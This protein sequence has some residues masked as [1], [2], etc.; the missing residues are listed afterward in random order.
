[1]ANAIRCIRVCASIEMNPFRPIADWLRRARRRNEVSD[2]PRVERDGSVRGRQDQTLDRLRETEQRFSFLVRATGDAVYDWDFETGQIEWNVGRDTMFG[3]PLDTVKPDLAWW[4]HKLHPDERDRIM[5]SLEEAIE[6]PEPSWLEEYRFRRADGGWGWVLDRGYFV[7]DESGRAVRMIGALQDLTN[8]HAEEQVLRES[9]SHFRALIENVSDGII[10]VDHDGIIRYASPSM[11]RLLGYPPSDLIGMQ[12]DDLVHPEDRARAAVGLT[13]RIHVPENTFS[14]TYRLRHRNGSWRS[15]EAV[16]SNLPP[17][18][19][20]GAVVNLR[21]LTERLALEKQLEQS[22][23]LSKLGRL[24]ATVAHEFNNVLMGIQPFAELI[25]RSRDD[26][27]VENATNRI[28]ASVQRGKNIAQEI[29]RYTRPTEPTLQAIDLREW[30]KTLRAELSGLMGSR[31]DLDIRDV[32]EPLYVLGDPL[33]MTQ[34]LVNLAINARDAMPEGGTLTIIAEEAMSWRDFSFGVVPTP[35]RFIHFI[36]RDTGTGIAPEHIEHIFEPLY[37]TKKSSGTGLGLNVANQIVSAHG[38]QMFVESE[39]GAG[40]TFHL[41]FPKTYPEL[42][43]ELEPRETTGEPPAIRQRVL[44][45]DEDEAISAGVA[46][47][48]EDEGYETRVI[49]EGGAAEAALADFRP[50]AVIIHLGLPDVEGAEVFRRFS[51][52]WPDLPVIF[53]TGYGD[54]SRL[55]PHLSRRNINFI[56]KPYD[57][58]QLFDLLTSILE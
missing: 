18:R 58:E 30:M 32:E 50:H 44:I 29:L 9:E 19:L 42:R 39:V 11:Q 27:V 36:V 54:E 21:D 14:L 23:H 57:A 38:G 20:T 33:Q 24:A 4:E 13:S 41:F 7:R 34:T 8:R 6:R 31:I 35:D 12:S 1:M 40:T 53:S 15:M 22:D 45:I 5:T 48:L 55:G 56:Q 37:S 28:L 51:P 2:P 43:E 26:T 16:A 25:R 10:V 46:A 3:Y 52:R 49:G 47:L 17:G